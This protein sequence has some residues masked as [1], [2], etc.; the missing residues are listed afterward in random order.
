MVCCN[1]V[2]IAVT[3]LNFSRSVHVLDA[4]SRADCHLPLHVPALQP[5][6]ARVIERFAHSE[7]SARLQDFSVFVK[8]NTYGLVCVAYI[9]C[10]ILATCLFQQVRSS[11]DF[12]FARA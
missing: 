4:G 8:L 6:S 5:Q 2:C 11:R 7:C 3:D 9:L 1:A 10:F 12:D